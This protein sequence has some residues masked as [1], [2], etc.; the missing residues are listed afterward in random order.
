MSGID[1]PIWFALDAVHPGYFVFGVHPDEASFWQSIEELSRDDAV[2]PIT[3]YAHPA[4]H[5]NVR[6]VQ[7]ITPEPPAG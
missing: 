1:V 2:C 3:V 5:V 4:R 6:F 7:D